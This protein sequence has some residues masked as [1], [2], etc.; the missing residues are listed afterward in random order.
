LTWQRD[1]YLQKLNREICRVAAEA[2]PDQDNNAL[3]SLKDNKHTS[4]DLKSSIFKRRINALAIPGIDAASKEHV[5]FPK[6]RRKMKLSDVFVSKKFQ[7]RKI[8]FLLK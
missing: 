8:R 6:K 2:R 3:G 7:L 1:A 4:S 5:R